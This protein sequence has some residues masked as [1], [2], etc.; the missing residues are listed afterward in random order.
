M[1]RAAETLR[2]NG[3]KVP[4]HQVSLTESL[5]STGPI[6]PEAH[7]HISHDTHHPLYYGSWIGRHSEDP[8]LNVKFHMSG[9]LS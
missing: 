4:E 9:L 8:A 3:I 5:E 1:Q 7:Y 6:S 2:K